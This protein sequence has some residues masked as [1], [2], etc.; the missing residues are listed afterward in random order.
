[1]P[2]GAMVSATGVAEAVPP[3]RPLTR[4]VVATV[5]HVGHAGVKLAVGMVKGV[6]PLAGDV[7]LTIWAA[8]GVHVVEPLVQVIVTALTEGAS[9]DAP[10][11]TVRLT[12]TETA[13]GAPV[14]VAVKVRVAAGLLVVSPLQ[15]A[16]V[17]TRKLR[18]AGVVRLCEPVVI[19]LSVLP[20]GFVIVMPKVLPVVAPVTLTTIVCCVGPRSVSQDIAI[21]VTG[22]VT[23]VAVACRLPVQMASARTASRSFEK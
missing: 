14:P 4:G 1:M 7:T 15:P 6:P 3:A 17:L 11:V 19:R 23:K 18:V 12:V 8:P 20:D 2:L 16:G 5:S 13:A 10:A 22:F 9:A 21:G